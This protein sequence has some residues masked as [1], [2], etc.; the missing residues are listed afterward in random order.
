MSGRRGKG[1]VLAILACGYAWLRSCAA[2]ICVATS[3]AGLGKEDPMNIPEFATVRT[4]VIQRN[5]G[6]CNEGAG[7]KDYLVA[8]ASGDPG[9]GS[10]HDRTSARVEIGWQQMAKLRNPVSR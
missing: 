10:Q 1:W 7:S 9:Q 3:H 4:A 6:L 5:F 2:R 8:M